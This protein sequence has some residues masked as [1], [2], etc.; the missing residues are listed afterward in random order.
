MISSRGFVAVTIVLLCALVADA[1]AQS[2]PEKALKP[3]ATAVL[4]KTR[5]TYRNLAGYHFERVLLVQEGREDGKLANI[6]ELTLAI[7]SEHA[8]PDSGLF[9]PVNL[10]RF[11]VRTKTKGNEMLQTCDGRICWSYTSLK[12]EYMKGQRF[13]DVNTS[14]GGSLMLGV[15]LFAFMTLEEETLQDVKVARE[16]EV[17]VGKGRRNCYV[18]EGVIPPRP[19]P[20]PDQPPSGRPGV[21]WFLSILALQGLAGEEGA[22]R[23]SLWPPDENAAGV[24]EPTR[25]TLWIDQNTHVVV[26]TKMSG[27]LYKLRGGKEGQLVEK[28]AVAVTDSFTTARIDGPPAD[29]FDFTP[30]QGAKEVPNAAS[31]RQ[32]Q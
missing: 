8:K 30:P 3:E 15:H 16:E 32:K 7:A 1:L 29:L 26:R 13:R 20:R 2:N 31:R 19:R 10:D 23:Y 27:Q 5:E 9:L 6:A 18:I 25:V 4:D 14:V 24:G 12:N 11:L 22:T 21:D 17:E 28:V